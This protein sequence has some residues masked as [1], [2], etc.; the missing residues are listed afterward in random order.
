MYTCTC[1]CIF[2]S[3]TGHYENVVIHVHVHVFCQRFGDHSV[4]IIRTNDRKYSTAHIHVL[5]TQSCYVKRLQKKSRRRT[6]YK[7]TFEN[8]KMH[9]TTPGH[10]RTMC[11][12]VKCMLY[13]FYMY[14]SIYVHVAYTVPFLSEDFNLLKIVLV[15][16]FMDILSGIQPV[17]A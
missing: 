17:R 13:V 10:S 6:K 1:F 4:T 7:I 9:N 5:Y 3:F 15:A 8:T 12:H 16:F 2:V 11:V 14:M